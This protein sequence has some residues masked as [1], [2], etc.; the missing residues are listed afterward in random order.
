MQ[1]H[2]VESDAVGGILL[3][4][5]PEVFRKIG[6]HP[7]PCQRHGCSSAWEELADPSVKQ[8]EAASWSRYDGCRME[9][10]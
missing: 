8:G 1:H 4:P 3:R 7:L 9:A 2:Q 10:E 6:G 5:L